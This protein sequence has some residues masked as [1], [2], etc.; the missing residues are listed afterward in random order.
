MNC[1]RAAGFDDLKV[2]ASM[3]ITD[4]EK[5]SI[6]KIERYIDKRHKSNQEIFPPSCTLESMNSLP[7]EF[8]PRHH[9]RICKFVEE[10]KQLYKNKSLRAVL[11]H[12]KLCT[13]AKKTNDNAVDQV[14]LSVYDF[15]CQVRESLKEWVPY[16]QWLS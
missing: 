16:L 14:L 5:N 1:M 13:T 2:I 9:I 11:P 3:N 10:I 15:N 4:D 7:F 6:S 8:P 12:T